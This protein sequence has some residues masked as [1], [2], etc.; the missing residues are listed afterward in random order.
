M[1]KAKK[2]KNNWAIVAAVV[3]AVLLIGGGA[4]YI[5]RMM[6]PPS[7][8]VSES[9]TNIEVKKNQK[10]TIELTSNASTGYS[11]SLNDTYD[12]NVVTKVS[13]KYEA[14]NTSLVGAPGKELWV[15]KGK[16]AG[17]TKLSFKYI[18]PWE[19]GA[20]PANSKTFNITVK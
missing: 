18:Q 20:T 5:Y 19:A 3:A 16:D 12:K 1:A 9:Q 7:I 2:T 11:W 4:F 15:F 13:N 10:F 6:Y 14:A 8:T 17:T